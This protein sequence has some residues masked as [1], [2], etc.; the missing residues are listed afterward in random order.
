MLSGYRIDT[1]NRVLKIK[2]EAEAAKRFCLTYILKP[3]LIYIA[4]EYFCAKL[5][6][7]SLYCH[8]VVDISNGKY[9]SRQSSD[10]NYTGSHQNP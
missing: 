3:V 4:F 10:R 6:C 8:S 2:Y 5:V 1:D 9:W 7:T